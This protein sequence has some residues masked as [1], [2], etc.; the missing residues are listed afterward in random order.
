MP[1]LYNAQAAPLQ[2]GHRLLDPA[3]E[4]IRTFWTCLA[5]YEIRKISESETIVS[6]AS[7]GAMD[8]SRGF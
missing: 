7:V 2:W 3:S 4:Q 6:G 1:A 8:F 5:S